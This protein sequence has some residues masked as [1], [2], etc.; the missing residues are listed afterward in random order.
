MIQCEVENDEILVD[1]V[2]ANRDLKNALLIVHVFCMHMLGFFIRVIDIYIN[3]AQ[4]M[5][6]FLSHSLFSPVF[7]F[8]TIPFFVDYLSVNRHKKSLTSESGVYYVVFQALLFCLLKKRK[9]RFFL[10]L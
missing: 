7:A 3:M 1:F 5:S 9:F 10:F 6:F 8:E 4:R 2:F